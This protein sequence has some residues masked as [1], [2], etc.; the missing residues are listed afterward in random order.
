MFDR[1]LFDFAKFLLVF[2]LVIG[3]LSFVIPAAASIWWETNQCRTYERLMPD[4][5]FQWEL[6]GGCLMHLPDGTWVDADDWLNLSRFQAE[7]TK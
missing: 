4:D 6:I 2:G 1:D 7:V 3:L 5:E